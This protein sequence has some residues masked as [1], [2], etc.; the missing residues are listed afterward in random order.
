MVIA[1]AAAS[2]GVRASQEAGVSGPPITIFVGSG[3]V[4]ALA[5]Q[6][7]EQEQYGG[8]KGHLCT[9]H[10]EALALAREKLST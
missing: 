7:M 3:P 9:S 2:R 6:A 1:L 8:V 10:E 4:A 5:S